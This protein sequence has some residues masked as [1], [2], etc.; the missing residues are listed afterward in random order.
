[1]RTFEAFAADMPAY[2]ARVSRECSRFPIG[3]LLPF[4]VPAISF[5]IAAAS[6]GPPKDSDF[7]IASEYLDAGIA[8]VERKHKA[9]LLAIPPGTHDSIYLGWALLA[10]AIHEQASGSTTCREKRRHLAGVF[11]A[12]LTKRNGAALNSYP[13]KCWPFDTV[14]GVLGLMLSDEIDHTDVSRD[15]IRRHLDWMKGDGLD[16]AFDLPRSFVSPKSGKH[17]PPRGC[18]LSL[19]Q[20]LTEVLDPEMAQR[21]WRA[22]TKHFW[23]EQGWAGGFREYPRGYQGKSDF[24]SGALLSGFGFVATAFGLLAAASA[25][26]RWRT[27]RL[28][29]MFGV[30]D[31]AIGTVTLGHHVPFPKPVVTMSRR[32]LDHRL[33]TAFLFGDVCLLHTVSWP[34]FVQRRQRG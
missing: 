15:A 18:D 8:A 5:S 10:L 25:G 16:P 32:L 1:M 23:Q 6:G 27:W 28:G 12:D 21:H 13:G 3:P 20:G 4:A 9:P 31:A 7:A 17:H 24:D 2:S 11:L 33:T 19:R 26:D 14:P 30:V 34:L 29:M 22:Y